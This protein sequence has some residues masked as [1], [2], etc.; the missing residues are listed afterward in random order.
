MLSLLL[1]HRDALQPA[2]GPG[3]NRCDPCA[4]PAGPCSVYTAAN[5]NAPGTT[6]KAGDVVELAPGTYRAEDEGEFGYVPA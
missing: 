6:I 4:N 1:L 3:W 2:R 5:E